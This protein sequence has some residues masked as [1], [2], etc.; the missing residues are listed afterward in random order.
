MSAKDYLRIIPQRLMRRAKKHPRVGRPWR[1]HSLCNLMSFH[2]NRFYEMDRWY[3]ARIPPPII[4][5]E[6]YPVD[7]N[8]IY[9]S[10]EQR[11]AGI[12]VLK[13]VLKDLFLMKMMAFN[14][15]HICKIASF[16]KKQ[17]NCH[18]LKC[19]ISLFQSFQSLN[20]NSWK[21]FND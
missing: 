7:P 6:C 19:T 18:Y 11:L 20:E 8:K 13:G 12:T 3:K 5:H 9:K 14:F 17:T 1:T 4:F 16:F 15:C 21:F 10:L 2:R